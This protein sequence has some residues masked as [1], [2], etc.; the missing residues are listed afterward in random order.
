MCSALRRM[1]PS[2]MTMV[3]WHRTSRESGAR[4]W[5]LYPTELKAIGWSEACR[6][7]SALRTAKLRPKQCKPYPGDEG[8]SAT[9]KG[10]VSGRF[11]LVA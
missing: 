11:E 2:C 4:I 8:G 7:C 3:S 6:H 10:F 1:C 9:F 5:L